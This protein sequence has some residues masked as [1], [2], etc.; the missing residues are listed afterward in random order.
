MES[1]I[2]G[3][4]TKYEDLKKFKKV[5]KNTSKFQCSYCKQSAAFSE[6]FE[7][8]KECTGKLTM[9]LEVTP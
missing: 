5:C 4:T 6:F 7:H 9:M 2:K 8:L 1:R 3:I